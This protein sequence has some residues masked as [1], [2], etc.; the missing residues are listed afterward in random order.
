MAWDF[1]SIFDTGEEAPPEAQQPDPFKQEYTFADLIDGKISIGEDGTIT[2]AGPASSSDTTSDVI[3]PAAASPVT[4]FSFQDLIDGKVSINEDG[5]LTEH[6]V[7]P[8]SPTPQEQDPAGFLS[9]D[10]AYNTLQ[11]LGMGVG[12]GVE[13]A[14]A[15]TE[16]AMP[17]FGDRL[18]RSGISVS[19]YFKQNMS[20]DWQ[21]AVDRSWLDLSREGAGR[22]W[23]SWVSG[24]ASTVPYMIGTGFVGEGAALGARALGLA[25][26]E[27]GATVGARIA[28]REA[29]KAASRK[30][31]YGAAAGAAGAGEAAAGAAAATDAAGL[32]SEQ[33]EQAMW[34]AA[35]YGALTGFVVGPKLEKLLHGGGS[36][37]S[38]VAGGMVAEGIEEAGTQFGTEV[39]KSAEGVGLDFSVAD[40]AEAGV[41]G[42]ALGGAAGGVIH[43]G[44]SRGEKRQA[45]KEAAGTAEAQAILSEANRLKDEDD[46]ARRNAVETEQ[47]RQTTAPLALPSPENMPPIDQQPGIGYTRQEAPPS[48]P[49]N[50]VQP[51]AGVLEAASTAA[52]EAVNQDRYLFSTEA[53]R[54]NF[55]RLERAVGDAGNKL[56]AL[57][58]KMETEQN[59]RRRLSLKAQ[60]VEARK[61]HA[62]AERVLNDFIEKQRKLTDRMQQQRLDG[63]IEE[64]TPDDINHASVAA[65]DQQELQD[66]LDRWFG[67]DTAPSPTGAPEPETG[68]EP[69][70]LK[71]ITE[72]VKRSEAARKGHITRRLHRQQAAI[73]PLSPIQTQIDQGTS[74]PNAAPSTPGSSEQ[75]AI[76]ARTPS[77]NDRPS[78]TPLQ[79]IATAE[80]SPLGG[81]PPSPDAVPA[82]QATPAALSSVAASP[83]ATGMTAAPGA[84]SPP[85]AEGPPAQPQRG[86]VTL[87]PS[88]LIIPDEGDMLRRDPAAI[89]G[90]EPPE[91]LIKTKP[92]PKNLSKLTPRERLAKVL[93]AG[94]RPIDDVLAHMQD[95]FNNETDSRAFRLV[96][97]LR[98]AMPQTTVTGAPIGVVVEARKLNEGFQGLFDPRSNRIYL[99]VEQ[100]E[101]IVTTLLHETVHAATLYKMRTN[102]AFLRDIYRI[103][104]DARRSWARYVSEDVGDDA[105]LHDPEEFVARILTDFELQDKLAALPASDN[106]P[107]VTVWQ[108]FKTRLRN[109]TGVRADPPVAN[110]FDIMMEFVPDGKY[111]Q[112][113]NRQEILTQ[114]D[115]YG[116]SQPVAS[117]LS[118]YRAM[119]R[120]VQNPAQTAQGVA[121]RL[122]RV[123]DMQLPILTVQQIAQTYGD[124]GKSYRTA[125]GRTVN[126]P[127]D[128]IN[129]YARMNDI[130]DG[131]AD[132]L[133]S[134]ANKII[135]LGKEAATAVG[136]TKAVDD[137]LMDARLW[138]LDPDRAKLSPS[139]HDPANAKGAASPGGEFLYQQL[140]ARF[141]ALHPIAKDYFR[142][143]RDNSA[144]QRFERIN[145]LMV[146]RA[147]ARLGATVAQQLQTM[148]Y[149]PSRQVSNTT[150]GITITYNRPLS[151]A[152]VKTFVQGLG[153]PVVK[154][155]RA[156][157]DLRQVSRAIGYGG[158]VYIP[159]RRTGQYY[160]TIS[161]AAKIPLSS[162][163]LTEAEFQRFVYENRIKQGDMVIDDDGEHTVVING[164]TTTLYRPTGRYVSVTAFDTEAEAAA[165]YE[166]MKEDFRQRNLTLDPTKSR[167]A[168]KSEKLYSSMGVQSASIA[169]LR[170]AVEDQLT[171]KINANVA[172]AASDEIMTYYLERLPESSVRKSQLRARKIAGAT[173]DSLHTYAQY[174]NGAAYV[175][176]QMKYGA[177]QND[178]LNKLMDAD[179]HQMQNDGANEQAIELQ[180][181]QNFLKLREANY[182]RLASKEATE[183]GTN[184]MTWWRRAPQ[185]VGAWLLTGPGTIITNSF[186]VWQLGLPYLGARHGFV[187]ASAQISK[188]YQDVVKPIL[189][190]TGS[191]YGRFFGRRGKNILGA[192]KVAT[193]AQQFTASIHDPATSMFEKAIVNLP[194]Q[195]QEII[196]ALAM[197]KKIDF[198]LTAD[199][200]EL[201]TR[202]SGRWAAIQYMMDGAFIAPQAAETMNRIVMGLSTARMER[203]RVTR[204]VHNDP[205]IPAAEKA[206]RIEERIT[207]LAAEA[208]DVT[209][210][211]YSAANRPLAFQS[212]GLRAALV[213]KTYPQAVW[214]T[215][216]HNMVQVINPK[217]PAERW[218]AMK[219]VGGMFATTAIAGGMMGVL[220]M[221]PFYLAAVALTAALTD[222]DDPEVALRKAIQGFFGDWTDLIVRGVPRGLGGPDV[223][224]RM[225][226]PSFFPVRDIMSQQRKPGDNTSA[227]ESMTAM[228]GETIMGAPGSLIFQTLWPA[229]KAMANG[230]YAT[231]AD[232]MMPKAFMLNDLVRAYNLQNRGEVDARGNPYISPKD[233]S[234][235]E[236]LTKVLGF[237]AGDIARDKASR[238][239][240]LAAKDRI[241]SGRNDLIARFAEAQMSR[242]RETRQEVLKEIV[243]WNRKQGRVDPRTAIRRSTLERSLRTRTE[244]AQNIARFGAQVQT[245]GQL[246]LLQQIKGLYGA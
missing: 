96:Q 89:I 166:S 14:G 91:A 115:N 30:L 86:G 135:A 239:A 246:R 77:N 16:L 1:A 156:Y 170:R 38:R 95:A 161:S 181:I 85:A 45:E 222:E 118:T 182:D 104:D 49:Y 92:R 32:T 72:A 39:G 114:L 224:N 78:S 225:G 200:R 143:V 165:E 23:R 124:L 62:T 168:L 196:R 116:L 73:G 100:A 233:I 192:A 184:L 163:A 185:L 8:Q 142:L 154:Q 33:R 42:A 41:A 187:S 193:G 34:S 81:T 58:Q 12:S 209:Q 159:L 228:I 219:F 57:R 190:E 76:R 235:P 208:I 204:E 232:R 63:I 94:P 188:A 7:V 102:E 167:Y 105:V 141:L 195:E 82:P 197:R 230:D 132:S 174:S 111:L 15:L 119:M 37:G 83:A 103:M 155:R 88:A 64:G 169:A 243:A 198:G 97:R 237:D 10:T 27:A 60:F 6:D 109:M 4:G 66:E 231:A 93:S 149:D 136:S 145:Q 106:Q 87:P 51:Q 113:G 11:S 220:A 80:P 140:R 69:P 244:N 121:R 151:M 179:I 146:W 236:I 129:Q 127:M 189:R 212:E 128:T 203:A 134:A 24:L 147:E 29:I 122:S 201:A 131:Y 245:P 17:E 18:R 22:D 2:P 240:F 40:I 210:V 152:E 218:T 35:P 53:G 216:L 47:Q 162:R 48:S 71:K 59:S 157:Q 46:L 158:P 172:K 173:R 125:A 54:A 43:K 213:F 139:T 160:A 123:W 205:T 171:S 13:V 68:E 110:L 191:E 186:Q 153:L 215:I 176:A 101:D 55:D 9:W 3:Q 90:T 19:D 117:L 74:L 26:K 221:D 107:K 112:D 52:A 148:I 126:L 20:P 223:S 28:S 202:S 67:Q 226:L 44:R 79:Q 183:I 50:P 31:G 217:T 5:S 194:A 234:L 164:I 75:A 207:D 199:I 227:Y 206:Q 238:R 61:Q 178:M 214:Y 99:D 177:V 242:D 211:N 25:G 137:I 133:R 229:G 21:E 120:Q 84:P 144:A 180:K 175:A 130:R 36:L 56:D 70:L 98:N 241:Q 65:M 138:G 150:A 108:R